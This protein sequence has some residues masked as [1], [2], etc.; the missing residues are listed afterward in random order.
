MPGINDDGRNVS[1]QSSQTI[2][3]EDGMLELLGYVETRLRILPGLIRDPRQSD[4][5]AL[6]EMRFNQQ[7]RLRQLKTL[8]RELEGQVDMA[9]EG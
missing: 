4:T 3:G 2:R 9:F 1:N 7:R 6:K 8:L 5:G